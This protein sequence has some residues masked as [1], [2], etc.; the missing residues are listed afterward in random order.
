MVKT[1]IILLGFGAPRNMS[2][3]EPFITHIFRGKKPPERVIAEMQERYLALGGTSPYFAT[4]CAQGK[5]LEE[6][7][8]KRGQN[9]TVHIGMLHSEP[10]ISDTMDQMIQKG[11]ERIIAITL[12]PFYSKVST[13]AYE[14]EIAKKVK[15]DPNIRVVYL[16]HWCHH[17]FFIES[18]AQ[19]IARSLQGFSHPADVRLVFTAHSLP[20]DPPEDAAC[21]DKQYQEAVRLIVDK[22][23]HKKFTVTYQSKGKRPIP[24]LGPFVEEVIDKLSS[25]GEEQVLIVPIGFVS[26]HMETLYDLDI[27]LKNLAKLVKIDLRR[28]S[29][30][31]D[32]QKFIQGLA[33]LVLSKGIME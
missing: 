9:I 11:I 21:Y 30:L 24:W 17:P 22:L 12:A 20:S 16:N 5:L 28:I 26:D 1:G 23:A 18:W 13:G 6:L 3:V 7:I 25:K 33:E 2:E 19:K 27:E 31:N 8:R 4:T 14:N 10:F 32:D 15:S 29:A